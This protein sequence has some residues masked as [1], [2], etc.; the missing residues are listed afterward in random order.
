MIENYGA[1][2]NEMEY[3]TLTIRMS[4]NCFYPRIGF[5]RD[6]Y[7]Y[8][9][10]DWAMPT[11]STLNRIQALIDATDIRTHVDIENSKLE[12]MFPKRHRSTFTPA[13][14]FTD[15]QLEAGDVQRETARDGGA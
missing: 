12:Y 15:A 1:N 10:T 11:E 8:H 14:M 2:T 3:R 4:G 7:H 5:R 13:A 9:N 6:G